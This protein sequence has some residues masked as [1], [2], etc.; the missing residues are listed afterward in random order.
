MPIEPEPV[1]GL[2]IKNSVSS[3][4]IPKKLNTGEAAFESKEESPL[5]D[6]NSTTAKIATRYGKVLIHKSTALRAPV[7]KQSYAFIFLIKL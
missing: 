1:N 2:K 5:M 7:T 3:L 4:G 6:N